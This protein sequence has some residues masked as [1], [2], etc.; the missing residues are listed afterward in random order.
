MLRCDDNTIYTGIAKDIRRRLKEHFEKS[1][2]CAKYTKTHTAKKAEAV[3]QCEDR[4]LASKLEFRIKRLS[5][6]QKERLILNNDFSV[7]GENISYDLY[8]RVSLGDYIV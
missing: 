3:W 6:E 7:F 4:V 5:K 1:K 8:V 2:R